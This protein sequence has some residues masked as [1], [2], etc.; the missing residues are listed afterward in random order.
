METI[1][2]NSSDA[3][4]ENII[5]WIVLF[6]SFAALFFF[7]IEYST[8][9]RVIDKTKSLS[10]Y[11]ARAISLGKLESEVVDGLNQI[12]GNSFVTITVADLSCSE[13]TGVENYQVIF[14]TYTTYENNF[15]TNQ[16]ANNI[17]SKT[18]VF[19]EISG[20]EKVCDLYVTL[21]N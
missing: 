8:S 17:N 7:T 11:G 9:I 16:G 4:I 3:Y 5:L 20:I 19:N 10:D 2:G 13:N 12:K 18:I 15:L 14:N 6:V 21:G 1:K